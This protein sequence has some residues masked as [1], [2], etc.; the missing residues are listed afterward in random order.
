MSTWKKIIG[1]QENEFSLGIRGTKIVSSEGGLEVKD[2][3]GALTGITA[4]VFYGDGSGLTSVAASTID[5]ANVTG[6][7][8]NATHALTADVAYE[9]DVA[10]VAGIGNI[11]TVNLN[12]NTS[13]YLSGNGSW[14]TVSQGGYKYTREFHVD[15]VNGNDTTGT[16]AYDKPYLTIMKAHSVITSGQAVYLHLGTYTENV[17]WTKTNTDIIGMSQGGAVLCSGTWTVGTQSGASVRIVDLAFSGTFTQNG[18]GRVFFRRCQVNG[19]FI[20]SSGE[21]LQ[22]TETDFGTSVSVTSGG[23]VVI[24]GGQIN[25]LTVNHASA[26][27]NVSNLI[28]GA[29][30]T[31][32]LGTL[33]VNDSIVYSATP[34]TPAISSAAGTAT[35]MYNTTTATSSGTQARVSLAGFWSMADVRYDR[36]NSTLTGTNLGTVSYSDALSVFGITSLGAVGNVRITGGTSGQFLQTNGSGNLVF[37][38]VNNVAI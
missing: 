15:P 4:N 23:S 12:G 8:A 33:L 24:K 28:S 20:K 36:A 21:Y 18:T 7:V 16:G 14:A 34:T 17:T 37:A 30:F 5:G 32:T 27:V 6:A 11:A 25:G 22:A 29:V 35:Y 2:S 38:T 1:T 3:S 9:V 31:N 10:N 13:Q 26:V 19:A